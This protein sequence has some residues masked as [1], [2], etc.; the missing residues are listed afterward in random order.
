MIRRISL[1][2]IAV[3]ASMQTNAQNPTWF[4]APTAEISA[5]YANYKGS[6]DSGASGGLW[7]F[8]GVIWGQYNTS[9]QQSD[10]WWR[11][12]K[13]GEMPE[14]D[15][16]VD[17]SDYRL[18]HQIGGK[19][20]Q[21]WRIELMQELDKRLYNP[22]QNSLID[23][24]YS[25]RHG[26]ETLERRV[27][28]E[29]NFPAGSV[30]EGDLQ[31]QSGSRHLTSDSTTSTDKNYEIIGK[32]NQLTKERP[33]YWDFRFRTENHS[34]D[35]SEGDEYRN[36]TFRL[37]AYRPIMSGINLTGKYQR[38]HYKLEGERPINI[39][40]NRNRHSV[41]GVGFSWL[42]PETGNLFQ[43]T[44]DWDN[45]EKEWSF[46]GAVRWRNRHGDSLDAE[47][48]KQFYG[49][50]GR[51]SFVKTGK[52]RSFTVFAENMID[53]RYISI[54][55]KEFAGLYICSPD[56]DVFDE[57]LCNLPG[58]GSTELLPGANLIP[59]FNNSFELSNRLVKTKHYGFTFQQQYNSWEWDASAS[60]SKSTNSDSVFQQNMDETSLIATKVVS[61]Q[62]RISYQWAYRHVR[63]QTADQESYDRLHKISIQHDI[64][65]SAQWEISYHSMNKNSTLSEFSYDDNRISFIYRL[66]F[67]QKHPLRRPLY[68]K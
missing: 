50:T 61:K 21:P 35:T 4:L 63:L 48:A 1:V 15:N 6:A 49:E 64:N 45:T 54:L 52:A 56:T 67:G 62:T 38:S 53:F 59:K 66:N 19:K 41:Y 32:I 26:D 40:E 30:V 8:K 60:R 36:N 43:L 11:F 31:A 16:K 2:F 13:T 37:V 55:D 44:R 34:Q 14:Y 9:H 68:P 20:E 29:Y 46:G 5:H 28:A 33:L 18:M 42:S 17:V 57:A 12:R 47:W 65:Q 25:E 7:G 10:V 22:F 23:D 3:S 58:N 27:V 24:L 39:S 51:L